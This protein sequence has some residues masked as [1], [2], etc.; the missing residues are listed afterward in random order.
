MAGV[1]STGLGS[2][3]DINSLVTGLIQAES[4]PTLTRLSRKEATLQ[5]ELSAIGLLK[6][7][8][9]DFQSKL[10]GLMDAE[11]FSNRTANSSDSSIAG[12]TADND[13][14]TG[15]YSLEI[16]NLASGHKLVSQN[17]YAE[18]TGTLEFSNGNGTFTVTIDDD[19]KGSLQLIRDSINNAEDN[20]GVT[21]T[22]INVN[23]SERLV[24]TTDDTGA[25]KAISIS[26]TTTT[27][28]LSIF[29]YTAGSGDTANFDE[30]IAAVD[31]QFM[32]DGQLITSASNTIE[33]VIPDATI[34]LKEANPGEPITLTISQNNSSIKNQITTL[35]D[36]YNELIAMINEQ[37]AFNADTQSS[38]ILFGDSLVSGLERQIRNALTTPINNSASSYTSLA[39]LGITTQ[40]DGTLQV[41]DS[42]LTTALNNDYAGVTTLF[43]DED[44]GIA[45][46]LDTLMDNYLSFNGTFDGRTDSINDKLSGIVD[47]RDKLDYRMTKLEA[48]LYAQYNAMDS[49]VYS[50]NQTGNW[51]QSTLATLPGS[52]S[53]KD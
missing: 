48:R 23:G 11:T 5:A 42:K 16:T 35:V 29:D 50:L 3:I 32:V 22:I 41:D 33:D 52:Y 1:S 27:G 30:V 12:F 7:A 47:E 25:D 28:D 51:L 34:T 24:F 21:A 2:G 6:S 31:A 40:S 49:L 14:A 9:S 19:N 17:A 46:A 26:S 43:S 10:G 44:Q 8:L 15:S 36:G 20:I 53:N 13:A 39:S 45:N 38:A 18:S 4:Q 37:T